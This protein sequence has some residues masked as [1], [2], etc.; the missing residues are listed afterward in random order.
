MIARSARYLLTRLAFWVLGLPVRQ[1]RN[2]VERLWSIGEEARFKALDELLSHNRPLDPQGEEVTSLEGLR[3]A[4]SL[5]KKQLR[6]QAVYLKWCW[7][8][9]R[10]K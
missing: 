3:A 5:S 10:P 9:G 6:A 4:P 2:E 8:P 1:Y 7:L